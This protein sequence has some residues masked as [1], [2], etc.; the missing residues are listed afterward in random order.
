MHRARRGPP[1][2]RM[3]P[4]DYRAAF[5]S[6]LAL[7]ACRRGEYTCR[8]SRPANG[9]AVRL[10]SLACRVIGRNT[11]AADARA[12]GRR[13]SSEILFWG[14]STQCLAGGQSK[15]SVVHSAAAVKRN[16][17]CGDHASAATPECV[18]HVLKGA[19]RACRGPPNQR[20]QP[21]AY[22]A[23]VQVAWR[24]YVGSGCATLA[25][26]CRWPAVAM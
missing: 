7:A 26:S 11:A 17:T 18:T 5:S 1:N 24:F 9:V 10:S 22:R 16:L 21:T 6:A 12:V 20:M 14:D 4:T 2:Q 23:A 19:H 13:G 15:R 3:Q 25:G 8:Q